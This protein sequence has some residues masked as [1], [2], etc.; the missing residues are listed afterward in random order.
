LLALDASTHG[1]GRGTQLLGEGRNTPRGPGELG[2]HSG[3]KERTF[4]AVVLDPDDHVAI[5][6]L[7]IRHDIRDAVD[8]AD[9]DLVLA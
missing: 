6:E 1:I 5:D 9:R 2:N 3:D 8:P 4:Q 7:G